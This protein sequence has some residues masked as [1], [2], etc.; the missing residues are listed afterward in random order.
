MKTLLTAAMTKD[1]ARACCDRVK[2]CMADIHRSVGDGR[3]SLAELRAG[4]GWLPLGYPTWRALLDGEFG[5]IGYEYARRLIS[6]AR[7]DGEL[8]PNES[9]PVGAL[10]LGIGSLPERHAR[11]LAA[12]ETKHKARVIAAAAEAVRGKPL[13]AASLKAAREA[14]DAPPPLAWQEAADGFA[15]AV[16]MIDDLQGRLRELAAGRYGKAL[17]KSMQNKADKL[18]LPDLA[19]ARNTIKF[20]APASCPKCDGKGCKRCEDRGWMPEMLARQLERAT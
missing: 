15:E 20:A 17:A 19:A 2:E 16:R 12:V 3:E 4:K 8:T 18:Y 10:S 6:A 9:A 1:K 11:E 5:G 13:T 14:L 7:V